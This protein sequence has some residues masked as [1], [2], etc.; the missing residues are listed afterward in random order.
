MVVEGKNE[1]KKTLL[2]VDDS[3]DVTITIK[4][5]LEEESGDYKVIIAESG[6]Q[7][8]EILNENKIP[9]A[10]LLDIMLPGIDGMETYKRIKKNDKWSF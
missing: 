3:T 9:D 7:C 5:V 4:G 2:V 8:L 10:I 6:E 1:M